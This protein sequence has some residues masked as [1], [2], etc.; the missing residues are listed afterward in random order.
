MDDRISYSTE[1]R[2]VETVSEAVA[3]VLVSSHNPL[4][5]TVRWDAQWLAKPA[6]ER[7]EIMRKRVD[8]GLEAISGEP[9]DKGEIHRANSRKRMQKSSLRGVRT[10]K[11]KLARRKDKTT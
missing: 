4:D 8:S 9:L 1:A 2:M 6:H 5:Y 3:K 11:A 10:R 7:V